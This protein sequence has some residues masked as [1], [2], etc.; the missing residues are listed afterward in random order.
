MFHVIIFIGFIPFCL[1]CRC[2]TL[3]HAPVCASN[4]KT[5]ENPCLFSCATKSFS[6]IPTPHVTIVHHKECSLRSGDALP[7]NCPTY[8]DPVCGDDSETYPNKCLLKC[9]EKGIKHKGQ[10]GYPEC[11]C[12]GDEEIVCGSDGIFYLNS[13]VLDCQRLTTYGKHW[14]LQQVDAEACLRQTNE[15]NE[16]KL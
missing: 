6:G 7:C 3:E 2:N 15:Y 12:P 16:K 9:A 10:C 8:F 14:K 1:S 4:G 5:Y 13:C 11:R